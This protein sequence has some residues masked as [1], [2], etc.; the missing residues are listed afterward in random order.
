MEPY[1][2]TVWESG[3]VGVLYLLNKRH[4]LQGTP[5]K[6]R[7]VFA[8]KTSTL[9]QKLKYFAVYKGNTLPLIVRRYVCVILSTEVCDRSFVRAYSYVTSAFFRIPFPFYES[10]KRNFFHEILA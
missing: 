3:V 4:A 9:L 5:V 6:T 1:L 7:R 8:D 10:A 2:S